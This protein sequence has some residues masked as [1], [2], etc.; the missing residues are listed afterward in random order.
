VS[1][2]RLLQFQL[3]SI[4]PPFALSLEAGTFDFLEENNQDLLLSILKKSESKTDKFLSYKAFQNFFNTTLKDAKPTKPTRDNPAYNDLTRKALYSKNKYFVYKIWRYK[5]DLT[6]YHADLQK[7]ETQQAYIRSI[8]Q[9]YR[10][11][12]RGYIEFVMASL[13]GDNFQPETDFFLRPHTCR[14]NEKA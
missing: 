8:Q 6:Q 9:N 10:N 11:N 13:S 12:P 1:I 2:A 7:Y 14:L 5:T 4:Y 3:D